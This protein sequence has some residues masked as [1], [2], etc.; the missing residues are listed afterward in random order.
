MLFSILAQDMKYPTLESFEMEYNT[1][2]NE[3]K[4]TYISFCLLSFWVTQEYKG[5]INKLLSLSLSKILDITG[6]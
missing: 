5:E 2:N 3:I 1:E 6:L 4:K